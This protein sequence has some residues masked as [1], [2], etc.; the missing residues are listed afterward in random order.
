MTTRHFHYALP[1][2]ALL[3]LTD[4]VLD[5]S[6]QKLGAETGG[7]GGV[8]AVLGGFGGSPVGPGG[9]PN[10]GSG[11]TGGSGGN[12]GGNGGIGGEGGSP[13]TCG[14]GTI[15]VGEECDDPLDNH[16]SN[17]Q[18]LC[19]AGWQKGAAGTPNAFHCYG[20]FGEPVGD[21]NMMFD[22]ANADCD[23][24]GANFH[25]ATLTSA[26]ER[27]LAV[28]MVA[29]PN[30]PYVGGTSSA[31]CVFEW[32]TGEPWTW[33]DSDWVGGAGPGMC[34]TENCLQLWSVNVFNDAS[35]TSVYPWIC[36]MDPPEAN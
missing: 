9:M 33:M 5:R 15:D 23:A 3:L 13:P 8:G 28:G 12:P 16:C 26:E 18:V 19:P 29:G 22:D 4:C 11:G 36:E 34:G 21:T 31:P 17:C 2:F 30:G 6:G 10:G 1:A 14:N 27:A 32:L 25:L 24:R 35:C 20:F 7:N